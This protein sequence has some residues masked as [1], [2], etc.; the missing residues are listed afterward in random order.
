M[1]SRKRAGVIAAWVVSVIGAA[2]WGY[3]Q[4]PIPPPLVPLQTPIYVTGSDLAFR[5]DGRRGDMPVG[6]FVI[7][8]DA[9]SQWVEVES[10]A[11]A[12]AP[13]PAGVE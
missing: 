6:R 12:A 10:A 3:A 5:V 7:R 2:V 9:Q 11:R 4:A 13:R 8:K 1:S